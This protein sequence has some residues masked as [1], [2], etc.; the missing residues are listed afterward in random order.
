M[1]RTLPDGSLAL[2]VPGVL[3]KIKESR[4]KILL[5]RFLAHSGRGAEALK[6]YEEAFAQWP[7][8]PE[9]REEARRLSRSLGEGETP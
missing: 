2:D 9:V 8:D 7:P 4:F 1:P 6:A 3:G 5:A